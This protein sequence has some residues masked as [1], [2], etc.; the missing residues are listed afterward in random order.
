MRT[1]R[2]PVVEHPVAHGIRSPSFTGGAAA[3]TPRTFPRDAP[4]MHVSRSSE[5]RNSR[6]DRQPAACSLGLIAS[7]RS[8]PTRL[9]LPRKPGSVGRSR[10]VPAMLVGQIRAGETARLERT[11]PSWWRRPPGGPDDRCRSRAAAS[12]VLIG[13]IETAASG[14]IQQSRSM[15]RDRPTVPGLRERS[16]E[17]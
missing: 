9:L 10:T 3:S 6:T 2:R 8:R 4:R 7:V 15:V 16:T 1:H 17:R 5:G 11:R 13:S 12:G 14:P